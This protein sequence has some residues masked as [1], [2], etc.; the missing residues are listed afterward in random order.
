MGGA[1]SKPA[2]Q[3]P[4]TPK[5]SWTGA[6]T[7]GPSDS[8]AH[9]AEHA[10]TTLPRA[11]ETKN[12]AIEQDS[13]D[14]QLAANLNRLGAVTVD[15]HM[16]T[17]R[18]AAVNQVNRTFQSRLQ[19][20]AEARSTK[21]I[22]NRLLASTLIDLLN[23]R[24]EVK[25]LDELKELADRYSID[26]DKMENLARFVNSPSIDQDSIK[27]SVDE[28]GV[29]KVKMKA[30]WTDPPFISWSSG[31]KSVGSEPPERIHVG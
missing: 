2:R 3:F 7:P 24:R 25:S 26:F 19:S 8:T 28:D 29:E 31:T 16:K 10:R 18:P 13:R 11:S 15:H 22:R 30:E 6:R 14:P 9:V 21:A 1:A 20:E 17:F 4:K 12:E 27:R 23:R 5:P